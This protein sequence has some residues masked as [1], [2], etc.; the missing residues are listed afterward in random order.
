MPECTYNTNTEFNL[1]YLRKNAIKLEPHSRIC[2]DLKIALE[3]STTTIVQLAFKSSLAKKR[4]NIREEII[5]AEYVKNIIVML[6]N[7]SKKAYIVE[8]NKKI[9]QTIFL[10]LV[11]ITQLALV[12]NREKLGIIAK[13]IQGI[14]FMSRI[15][16]PINMAE[17]KVIDKRE[18]IFNY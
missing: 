14:R 6:Q 8:L 2:I 7:N 18:I 9:T 5:D 10:P 1:R 11:K 12:R 4:I 17:K 15:N 13:G 16:V 3:I